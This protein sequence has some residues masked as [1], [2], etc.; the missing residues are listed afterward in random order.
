MDE[1]TL[2]NYRCFGEEQ[3]ARLTP[4]TL[5]VGANSTGKTSFLAI[6]RALADV[7]FGEIVPDFRQDP[8]DL[9][10]FQDIVHNPTN[11]VEVP[12]S[13][14]AGFS[15]SRSNAPY[16]G[17]SFQVTFDDRDGAPFPAIRVISQDELRLEARH[18]SDNQLVVRYTTER[19][20]GDIQAEIVA[21]DPV[22][23]NRIWPMALVLPP[24]DILHEEMTGNGNKARVANSIKREDVSQLRD[25]IIAFDNFSDFRTRPF[26]GTPVTF[27][28]APIR[29]RPRRTYDPVRSSYDAEG[30]YVPSY[31][32]RLY[33]SNPDGWQKLKNSIEEFGRD[34]EMFDEVS[35]KPFGE[36]G[37]DPFQIQIRFVKGSPR[38]FIDV[39]Y[40]VSQVLPILTELFQE[41]GA[42]TFLL[43]QPEVHLHPSAQAAIGSLFCNLAADGKQLIVETHSDHIIDRVR[44]EVRDKTTDLKP[45]D[46]SILYFER[47]DHDVRI[48]SLRIDEMGNVSGAPPTYRRFFMEEVRR[49]I[50]I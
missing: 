13:F 22:V 20:H 19:S 36:T 46:V 1:I 35:V 15:Y 33:R 7:A 17:V 30:E 21:S 2:K 26:A 9:G 27:A 12:H 44:M 34:S 32:A 49:S 25:L 43:Q 37:G 3:T 39:G 18:K 40:G 48:H 45:E 8:Y 14:E 10:S 5:L 31:L 41:N 28:G 24:W 16:G 23:S 47:D 4:L 38:N 50:G 29:S 11:A 42:K 6:I